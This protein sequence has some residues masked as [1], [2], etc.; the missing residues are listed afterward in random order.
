MKI[1]RVDNF[2]RDNKPDK[3]VAENV[4]L[5]YADAMIKDLNDRYSG[6]SSPYFFKLVSDSYELRE[7]DLP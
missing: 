6:I 4:D 3:L 1:I 5:F 2:D 7:V